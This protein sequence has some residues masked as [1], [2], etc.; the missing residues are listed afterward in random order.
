MTSRP[1][2]RTMG[3]G[4]PG[5]QQ[6]WPSRARE[7]LRHLPAGTIEAGRHS[8][9]R[10]LTA[11]GARDANHSWTTEAWVARRL[12]EPLLLVGDW[13]PPSEPLPV[14]DG[15]VHADL[16][17]DDHDLFAGLRQAMAEDG[18]KL[19]PESLAAAAQEFRLP[20]T[21]YRRPT[22]ASIATDQPGPEPT[23]KASSRWQQSEPVVVDLTALWAGPL[24]TSLLAELGARV[25]K[26][27]PDCRPD[28]L[29]EYEPV[30]RALNANKT[31]VDLDL[32]LNP[33]REHF[34]SL[35]SEANLLV[36]SFSRRVMTNLGYGPDELRVRFPQLS[37]L[38]I[39]AFPLGSADQDWVSYG[40][41]VHAAS[42]LAFKGH[43]QIQG[44]RS[45]PIAYPDVLAGL[46]AFAAG[47]E[48]LS[49]SKGAPHREIS[50][51]GA[52]E[53]VIARRATP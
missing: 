24:G 37:T 50:L 27:D 46:S 3:Q 8:V 41:G 13:P 4:C 44:P 52:L 43:H 16:T 17:D 19:E 28:G 49:T 6:G 45:A 42:G 21:P 7:V 33:Q 10:G 15:A 39:V 38:S 47:A 51:A 14:G 2:P 40:P 12:I 1:T 23:I 34:E 53:P 32:R 22:D 36:D 29:G 9:E 30:Y 18:S 26:V 25:I 20:V 48:I 5:Y 31:I 35:L 11:A